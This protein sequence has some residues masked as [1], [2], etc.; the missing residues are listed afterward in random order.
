MTEPANQFPR[1]AGEPTS[2]DDAIQSGTSAKSLVGTPAR[3]ERYYPEG[4]FLAP[5]ADERWGRWHSADPHVIEF[6]TGQALSCGGDLPLICQRGTLSPAGLS[7][8]RDAGLRVASQVHPYADRNDYPATVARLVSEGLR[9]IMPYWNPGDIGAAG[10]PLV[11]PDLHCLLN[12]KAKMDQLVP[13]AGLPRRRSI[14]TGDIAAAAIR[15]EPLPFVV[16]VAT[17]LPN[18][19]GVDV[20]IVR[21]DRHRRRA[22]RQFGSDTSLIVE[23]YLEIAHNHCVQYAVLPD[24]SVEYLGSSAQVCMRNGVHVGNIVDPAKPVATAA[25]A[26]GRSIAERGAALGFRGIAGFDIVT[27]TTGETLA[28]DLNFRLVSSTAQVL[29][30]EELSNE[31]NLPLSRLVFCRFDGELGEMMRRCA[32]GIRSGW[33]APL[34]TFDPLYGQLGQGQ[35]RARMLVFGKSLPELEARLEELEVLG[36]EIAGRPRA[37]FRK[38]ARAVQGWLGMRRRTVR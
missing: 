38:I 20:A 15:H 11:A 8:M 22:I 14:G 7:A 37:P 12:N 21:K 10:E 28:L 33:L 25:I 23:A 29:L 13:E 35:S 2:P 34:A 3:L 18:A 19:G 5:R 16:K 27:T 17:D 1:G 6:M 32:G 26:L 4:C 36:V 31:R 9:P 30:H 24:G